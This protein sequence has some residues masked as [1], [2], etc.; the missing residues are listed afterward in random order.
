LKTQGQSQAAVCDV[1]T[2]VSSSSQSFSVSDKEMEG[3]PVPQFP[4]EQVIH[5]LKP[6]ILGLE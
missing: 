1:N 6:Q 3:T 2:F 4:H 5:E